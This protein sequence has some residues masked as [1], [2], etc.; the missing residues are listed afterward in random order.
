MFAV[1][2]R[3][4]DGALCILV[5]HG[6]ATKSFDDLQVVRA[7]NRECLPRAGR[8]VKRDLWQHLRKI[9]R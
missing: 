5:L 9:L 1:E 2:K 6:K 3:I 4:D 7:G 8:Q